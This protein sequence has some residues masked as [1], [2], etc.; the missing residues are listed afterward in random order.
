M[1]VQLIEIIHLKSSQWLTFWD[2]ARR[3]QVC[4]NVAN[5]DFPHKIGMIYRIGAAKSD[6]DTTLHLATSDELNKV[7]DAPLPIHPAPCADLPGSG[8]SKAGAREA[9]TVQVSAAVSLVTG[10]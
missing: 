1:I 9:G 6:R 2:I 3:K 5:T 8:R 10:V 4:L 7:Q